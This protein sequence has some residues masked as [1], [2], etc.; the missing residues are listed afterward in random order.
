MEVLDHFSMGPVPAVFSGPGL[1]PPKPGV[2]DHFS[3][4][5]RPCSDFWPA[6]PH[7]GVLDHLS[8]GAV[9]APSSVFWT[10]AHPTPS[11]GPES[12]LF[13]S[14]V[15]P[16]AP[17]LY[18]EEMCLSFYIHRQMRGTQNCSWLKVGQKVRPVENG[19]WGV[20]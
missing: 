6:A 18:F 13:S 19:A 15:L 7:P 8:M 16:A 11:V 1:T 9:S 3:N 17:H 10:G 20:L 5:A 2:L 14:A 12:M 4:G